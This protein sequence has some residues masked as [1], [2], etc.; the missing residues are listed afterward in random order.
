MKA[1]RNQIQPPTRRRR[2]TTIPIPHRHRGD[3][4]RSRGTSARNVRADAGTP[5]R[6]DRAGQQGCVA[7]R[8]PPSQSGTLPNSARN[9]APAG[10]NHRSRTTRRGP[11]RSRRGLALGLP[12]PASSAAFPREARARASRH[13]ATHRARQR[14]PSARRK[15]DPCPLRS[16]SAPPCRAG[17]IRCGSAVPPQTVPSSRA[18]P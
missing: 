2:F 6:H 16:R 3:R 11:S 17:Y 7:G 12:I 5:V 14:S 4:S 13:R 10:K 8:H 1:D 15:A 18:S 9:L